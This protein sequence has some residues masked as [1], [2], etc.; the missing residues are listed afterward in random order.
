MNKGMK[1][2]VC[3][4]RI[5]LI[6]LL[7]SGCAGKNMEENTKINREKV[8][9][10][11]ETLI[12]NLQANFEVDSNLV[13]ET[14]L[15]TCEKQAVSAELLK[16]LFFSHDLSETKVETRL[17]DTELP[18]FGN[19]YTL[20]S[21]EGLTLFS[22]CEGA[23]GKTKEADFYRNFLASDTAAWGLNGRPA[24]LGVAGEIS[25]LNKVQIENEIVAGLSKLMPYASV[26]ELKF[27]SLTPEYLTKIQNAELGRLEDE[28]D[29]S[30]YEREKEMVKEWKEEEGAYYI[31]VE[32]AINQIPFNDAINQPLVDGTSLNSYTAN[33]IYNKNGCVFFE[34]PKIWIETTKEHQEMI[35]AAEALEALKEDMS[36]IILTHDYRIEGAEIKYFV[37]NTP[38]KLEFEIRPIWV[39]D[40][41]VTIEVVD[42]AGETVYEINPENFYVDAV[43]SEVLR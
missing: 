10:E 12:E 9:W 19:A 14:E 6:C 16:E 28:E 42:E 18:E 40:S 36:L 26:N 17:Y 1:H 7:V 29:T 23:L 21:A 34:L 15:Y 31:T 27:Y 3:I 5:L 32:L 25:Y 35:T 33:F 13:R 30:W 41:K 8:K 11:N 37:I 20:T 24:K 43:T 22:S 38:S 39:F 4:L 2:S